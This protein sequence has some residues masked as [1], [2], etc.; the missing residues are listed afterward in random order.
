MCEAKQIRLC[1]DYG[2]E[3]EPSP[4]DMKLGIALNVK[5]GEQPINGLR[6]RS[7]GDTTGWYIWAGEQFSTAP[8]FFQPLHVAHLADWCPAARRFLGL[9]PGWRFLI[10]PGYEDV[11]FDSALLEGDLI[12]SERP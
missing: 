1:R 12:L 6:H 8:D 7:K 5:T 2:A 11:W 4:M 9:A 10:A 3:F